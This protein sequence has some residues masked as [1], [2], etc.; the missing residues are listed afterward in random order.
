MTAFTRDIALCN[1]LE[2][3]ELGSLGVGGEALGA[4]GEALGVGAPICGDI[5]EAL[6]MVIG[7]YSK[8]REG[9]EDRLF[10]GV[11]LLKESGSLK[12][13]TWNES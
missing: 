8:I 7:Q 10:V 2:T 9:Q 13:M 1:D 5:D 4:G 3:E 12:V 6:L 11:A